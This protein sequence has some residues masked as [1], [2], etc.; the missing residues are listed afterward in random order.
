MKFPS[1]L[2]RLV[3]SAQPYPDDEALAGRLRAEQ[4]K[5]LA[6]LAIFA[7]PAQMICALGLAWMLHELHP[8]YCATWVALLSVVCALAMFRMRRNRKLETATGLNVTVSTAII[9]AAACLWGSLPIVMLPR[10]LTADDIP[11]IL[12]MTGIASGGGIIFQSIP[13]AAAGWVVIVSACTV[14]GMALDGFAHLLGIAGSAAILAVVLLRNIWTTSAQFFASELLTHQANELSTT[15]AQHALVIENTSNAVLLLDEDRRITWGNQGFAQQSGYSLQNCLGC[16]PADWLAPEEW[17]ST[18]RLLKNSL[19]G[20]AHAQTK[21]RYR[22][23]DGQWIWVNLDVKCLS[24]TDGGKE[25]YVLIA[26]DITDLQQTSQVLKAEQIRQRHIIDGTHCGTWEVDFDGGVCKIG[27]HWLDIV[28]VDT[29]VPLVIDSAFLMGRIHPDDQAGHRQALKRYI[30]GLAPQYVHEHRLRNEAGGWCWVSARGKASAYAP[31]GQITQLSGISMDISKSKATELALIEAMRLAKQA[32]HAK[33]LFLATMSHEIR[34]PMNGV[35]G[36]AEWLKVTRLDEVQRDG[37]QTIVDS[38]HSLL[39]IIDDILDFTKIDAGH[40]K[41][42]ESVCSLQDLAESVVDAIYPVAIG[43]N[44][45]VHVFIDPRLPPQV[46]GDANRLRQ[47]MFNLVGNA[48]K[49]GSGTDHR[50]GQVDVHI[51]ASDDDPT[52]WQMQISD[53]GIGMTQETLCKLFRPFSQ[54]EASTTRRFGGTGLGLAICHRLVELM[55]GGI[56]VHSMPGHGSTFIATLPLLAPSDPVQSPQGAEDL[57]GVHCVLMTGT[58]YRCDSLSAYLEHAGATINLCSTREEALGVTADMDL[59]VLIQDTPTEVC[60]EAELQDRRRHLGGDHVRHLWIGRHQ[61]GPVRLVSDRI[62]QLGRAHVRDILRAVSVLAGRQSPEL[63]R[64][65]ASDFDEFCGALRNEQRQAQARSHLILVA[66]DDPTNQKVVKRQLQ[67]LGFACEVASDGLAAL[68]LW[69]TGRFDI[70]LSDLH[71]PELDG[72]EL[73]R[74]IRKEEHDCDSVRTPIL[75]LTANALAGEEVHARACGIDDYL[76]K[77]I[78]LKALHRALTHWLPDVGRITPEPDASTKP[79]GRAHQ[80]GHIDL[81]TLQQLV[82]ND[83]DVIQELLSEF[84]SSS[85]QIG[86]SLIEAAASSA[87]ERIRQLAHQLKSAARAIGALHLGDLCEACEACVTSP[88]FSL[89]PLQALQHELHLVQRQ[90]DTL[91]KEPLQ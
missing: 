66:E 13:V 91:I 25:R 75:A 50:H 27:G 43:K 77:P 34:T 37:I 72:Y 5:K 78:S 60:S 18:N 36:T 69:R 63:V 73:A 64:A 32:N 82:G 9:W 40:M 17:R 87:P 20:S 49:F 89:A 8:V 84:A 4:L 46:M 6:H 56:V 51:L 88:H 33:S 61:H 76:T 24:A 59:A 70:L 57:Q 35:I 71:M 10:V 55:G 14:A 79:H 22:H 42:E 38:G 26:T 12:A 45:D 54:A 86:V 7:V 67:T 65:D 58:N 15:L 21:L 2:G 41:L 48:V 47:V 81:S 52:T 11:V 28:G 68:A 62:G 44:V 31:N 3:H 16:S 39:T 30:K 74:Q 1:M 53:D 19:K 83:K 90:L 85:H 29:T 80:S 23:K